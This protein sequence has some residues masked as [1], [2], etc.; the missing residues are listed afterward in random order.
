MCT[1]YGLNKQT[2]LFVTPFEIGLECKILVYRDRFLIVIFAI[3]RVYRHF[4][5]HEEEKKSIV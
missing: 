2:Q 5:I 1:K 3:T 4:F